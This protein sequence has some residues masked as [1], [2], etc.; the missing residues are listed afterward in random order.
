MKGFLKNK[1]LLTAATVVLSVL[2]L[3][4]GTFAWIT[5]TDK[6][7]NELTTAQIIDSAV[8]IQEVFT[9]Q[10]LRPDT[11]V[12]KLVSM[13][14][15]GD[16]N[17]LVRVA[18]EE[19]LGLVKNTGAPTPTNVHTGT[20]IPVTVNIS[21][22]SGWTMLDTAQIDASALAGGHGFVP[23]A[24]VK[25]V[26]SQEGG[27]YGYFA[28]RDIAGDGS[29]GY[30]KVEL[31]KVETV[32]YEASEA[33]I[34]IPKVFG[35]GDIEL[36]DVGEFKQVKLLGANP[37][38]DKNIK[39]LWYE[40][41]DLT[42]K[43]WTGSTEFV[44]GGT[45]ATLPGSTTFAALTGV[46]TLANTAASTLDGMIYMIFGTYNDGSDK[47]AVTDNLTFAVTNK[48][49]FY[50]ADDGYFYYMDK[51]APGTGT[52]PVL[53]SIYMHGSAGVKYTLCDY[54]LGVISSAVQNS[55]GAVDSVWAD[56]DGVLL[57]AALKALCE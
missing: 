45:L 29:A 30:Q 7:L 34:G 16:G 11:R 48:L 51:V 14:N 8:V 21:A 12:D 35:G 54:K 32:L 26:Y 41:K 2:T 15:T 22:Y 28:Y 53:D 37:S 55:A 6:T 18:F 10:T 27:S 42:Y 57:I 49:W 4:S 47:P 50:N 23:T 43:T 31:G 38:T 36:V 40:G 33:G 56:A 20:W 39:F 25:I 24:N 19:I 52:K 13:I 5:S 3:A 1:K 17:V 46:S 9:P 44:P